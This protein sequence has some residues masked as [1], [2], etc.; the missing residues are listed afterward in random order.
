MRQTLE[1]HRP[2]N[3]SHIYLSIVGQ[4]WLNNII[5]FYCRC[6]SFFLYWNHRGSSSRQ[7]LHH[8][9]DP[10]KSW[11]AACKNCILWYC[12][13]WILNARIKRDIYEFV[14][15]CIYIGIVVGVLV[16]WRLSLRPIPV[17]LR[18]F[19]TVKTCAQSVT[20]L[21]AVILEEDRCGTDYCW[22]GGLEWWAAVILVV[23]CDSSRSCFGQVKPSQVKG[24]FDKACVPV[25]SWLL[26]VHTR[27][28]KWLFG[29]FV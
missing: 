27:A 6:S 26:A 25:V 5:A 1:N 2:P 12:S 15:C 21:V 11:P 28:S 19:T 7:V 18:C 23:R 10:L 9:W 4:S 20:C 29:W 17:F 13:Y 24:V 22:A 14:V 16:H 3:H 8:W